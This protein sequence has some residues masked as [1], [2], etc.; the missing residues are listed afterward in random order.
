LEQFQGANVSLVNAIVV[1]HPLRTERDAENYVAAL[2]Q[3]ATRMEEATAEAQRLASNGVLPPNFILRSTIEK[4]QR[5]VAVAPV[6]NPF[7]AIFSQKMGAIQAL[8]DAKRDELRAHHIR[9]DHSSYDPEHIQRNAKNTQN[10]ETNQ[11]RGHEN[12]QNGESYFDGGLPSLQWRQFRR[13]R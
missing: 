4:M 1:V 8:S 3:V 7:V 5:F 12:N 10:S 9:N 2:G 11:C 13:E 6:Q